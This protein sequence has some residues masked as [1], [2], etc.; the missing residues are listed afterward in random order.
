MKQNIK[1]LTFHQRNEMTIQANENKSS[2]YKTF[3]YPK[4]SLKNK[5]K[6]LISMV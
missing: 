6:T 2:K 3:L 5:T 4:F 1:Y